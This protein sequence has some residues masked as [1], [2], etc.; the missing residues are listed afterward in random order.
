MTIRR[1]RLLAGLFAAF[2]VCAGCGA[3]AP[4]ALAR[5]AATTARST[6]APTAAGN[7][8]ATRAELH[9]L[10]TVVTLPEGARHSRPVHALSSPGDITPAAASRLDLTRYWWVPKPIDDVWSYFQSHPPAGLT[11]AGDSQSSGPSPAD[12]TEGMGWS[13]PDRSFATSL[14]LA[15][16]LA[17]VRGGTAIRVDGQGTWLDPRP[18]RDT[19]PGTRVRTT[20]VDGCPRSV[21]GVVGVRNPRSLHRALASALLP[22]A[23]PA[24]GLLCGYAPPHSAAA[25]TLRRSE[26][27]TAAQARALADQLALVPLAQPP[28]TPRYLCP[29]QTLGSYVFVFAYP[30]GPDV[31]V[32][33]TRACERTVS[34][35]VIRLNANPHWPR[36]PAPR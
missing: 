28:G 11:S 25:G 2:A 5:V 36:L 34:N 24:R 20:V 19:T 21:R 10:L 15:V 4:S 23:R 22:A 32:W 12:R 17:L 18:P 3:R 33:Y 30:T 14:V 29:A 7:R 6:P 35:G 9:R 31:D 8:R 26:P 1:L 27:L 16:N 13:E